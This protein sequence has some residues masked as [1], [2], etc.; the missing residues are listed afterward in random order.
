MQP[1]T[2]TIHGDF[3]DSFIYKGKLY[4]WGYNE[5]LRVY[6]WDD[7]I[8]YVQKKYSL[9]NYLEALDFS[10]KDGRIFYERYPNDKRAYLRDQV[11]YLSQQTFEISQQELL[12][13][14]CLTVANPFPEL[15]TDIDIF[16]DVIYAGTDLGLFQ[17]YIDDSNANFEIIEQNEKLWGETEVVRLKA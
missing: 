12:D 14:I 11:I 16:N 15:A 2:L 9:L 5:E 7:I 1:V 8:D 13:F 4:L 3:W 10:F 6:Y 17:A